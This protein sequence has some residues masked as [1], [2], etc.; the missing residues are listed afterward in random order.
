M[1]AK[2]TK[3]KNPTGKRPQTQIGLPTELYDALDTL[4]RVNGIVNPR[5]GHGNRTK[6]IER[7]FAQLPVFS[8]AKIAIEI[9]LEGHP[10]AREYAEA[11]LTELE[12]LEIEQAYEDYIKE[13]PEVLEEE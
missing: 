3:K 11:I 10:Q 13:H 4:G 9:L 1:P 5:N 8:K 2:G 6:V 7:L 12:D